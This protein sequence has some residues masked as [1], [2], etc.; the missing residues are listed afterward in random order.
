LLNFLLLADLGVTRFLFDLR[1]R[2]FLCADAFDFSLCLAFSLGLFFSSDAGAFGFLPCQMI[3]MTPDEYAIYQARITNEMLLR[4]S[5]AKDRRPGSPVKVAKKSGKRNLYGA[6]RV[7]IMG[8][9][10]DSK[11][12][13]KR[14]LQLKAMEQAGEIFGL[15][16]QAEYELIPAQ[17]VGSH[18]E[19]PVKYVCDFRYTTKDGNRVVEDV[20]SAP[21]KTRE[22]IIKR[23]L[24]LW[25]H[26]IMVKEVMM[27]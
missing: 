1:L 4:A 10:F 25:I 22:F 13:G 23:K 20:K 18:K 21:T 16:T 7:E 14:F 17:K 11:A 8:I 26:G 9:Q 27:A 19:R 2:A 24:M 6:E 12:E 5:R 15:E 3:R